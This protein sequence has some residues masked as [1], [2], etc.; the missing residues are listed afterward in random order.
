[1]GSPALRAQPLLR[2]VWRMGSVQRRARPVRGSAS[3]RRL[4]RLLL[5]SP[6]G[7]RRASVTG[8]HVPHP[9]RTGTE[10]C[11]MCSLRVIG[12]W[13]DKKRSGDRR[14]SP[15]CLIFATPAVADRCNSAERAAGGGLIGAGTGAQLHTRNAAYPSQ[16]GSRPR[17]TRSQWRTGSPADRK[18]V[19]SASAP[20]AASRL[21]DVVGRPL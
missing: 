5:R 12:N 18:A 3:L 11:L 21:D 13:A 4:A 16:A 6:Q 1:M 15:V 19:M 2:C 8:D 17:P 10:A 20:N 7:A 14:Y 9:G